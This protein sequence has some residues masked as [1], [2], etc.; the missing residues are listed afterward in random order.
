MRQ[1][2]WVGSTRG[3]LTLGVVVGSIALLT[4]ACSDSRTAGSVSNTTPHSA[5]ATSTSAAPVPVVNA[6]VFDD[7]ALDYYGGGGATG[8][9]FGTI[10]V[11][12]IAASP[13]LLRGPVVVTGVDAAGHAVTHAVSYPV[14][15]GLVLSAHARRVPVEKV[16]PPGEAVANISMDAH[17]RDD[18]ASPDGLCSAHRVVPSVWELAMGGETKRVQNASYDPR[19]PTNEFASLVTCYGEINTPESI[20]LDD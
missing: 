7:L 11:R 6:C 5:R 16:A 3:L 12:D 4:V 2:E 17:Y 1:Y 19:N 18:P 9:D 10:R 8:N 13:C 14:V 15:P 20:R